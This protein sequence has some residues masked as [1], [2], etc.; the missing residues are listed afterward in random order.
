MLFKSKVKAIVN[1][2]RQKD[3]VCRMFKCH[4]EF[5]T[6]KASFFPAY[7][8]DWYNKS[9]TFLKLCYFILFN[10]IL[11]YLVDR[12]LSTVLSQK[13]VTFIRAYKSN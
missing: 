10:R 5:L 8:V 9:Q 6:V 4:K 7:I 1:C 3:T 13:V 11:R 12:W 2:T